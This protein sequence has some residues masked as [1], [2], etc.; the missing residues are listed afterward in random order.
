VAPADG[1]GGGGGGDAGASSGDGGQ[2]GGQPRQGPGGQ[3][4]GGQ[5]GEGQGQGPGRRRR[6]R[7]TRPGGAPQGPQQGQNRPEGGGAASAPPPRPQNRPQQGRPGGHPSQQRPERQ[8]RTERGQQQWQPRQNANNQPVSWRDRQ[9]RGQGGGDQQRYGK[10]RDRH[11]PQQQRIAPS[12][13][14]QGQREAFNPNA[15]QII[16]NAGPWRSLNP[17][18]AN[19]ATLSPVSFLE[20]TAAAYPDVTAIIYGERRYSYADLF[21][22]ACLLGSALRDRGIN[23]GDVVSVVLPNVPAMIEAHFGVPMSGAVLNVI[24]PSIDADALARLIE[25][26]ETKMIITDPQYADL[27]APALDQLRVPPAVVDVHDDAYDGPGDD[28]GNMNYDGLLAFGDPDYEWSPPRNESAPISLT[29]TFGDTGRMRGAVSS[30]RAAWV[31]AVGNLVA[32][33]MPQSPVF[34]W[35]LPLHTAHGWG[36]IWSVTALAG[37]HVCMRTADP[38]AIS[39]LAAE[40][41]VT[42]AAMA[43]ATLESFVGITGRGK[44]KFP[45]K[46]EA[47]VGAGP[48]SP[49]AIRTT[50]AIGLLVRRA[51]GMSE[52]Q[53]LLAATAPQPAWADLEPEARAER[54]GR[55]GARSV[56][57]A[58][59]LVVDPDTGEE[60]PHDGAS[61]GELV[62][63]GNSVM[64]GYLK[65]DAANRDAFAHGWFNTGD[66]AVCHPDGT[67]QVTGRR[68]EGRGVRRPP[69][70]ARRIEVDDADRDVPPQREES[71]PFVPPPDDDEETYETG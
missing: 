48:V 34:A 42:H 44:P 7:R 26:S 2:G 11:P 52:V 25:H 16:Y 29:Y 1:G 20:R 19:L 70:P 43:A 71:R 55:E 57:I 40:H 24:D 60:V 35:A 46:L 18:D 65:D 39:K 13:G 64:L 30:H 8:D 54:V 61:I 45:K 36:L 5:G 6:G 62:V 4:Q 37:T 38:Q 23:P 33:P 27:V 32:W 69:Q 67:L 56:A 21:A 31:G 58:S 47:M 51:L 68:A 15:R 12:G 3:G 41:G 14:G 50:E 17:G 59:Q 22:R 66:L 10:Q 49:E 63:R 9:N 53:G 28:V